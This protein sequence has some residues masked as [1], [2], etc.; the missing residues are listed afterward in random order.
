[1]RGNAVAGQ[2]WHRISGVNGKSV[3]TLF[4]TTYVYAASGLFKAIAHDPRPRPTPTPTPKPTPTPAATPK[5]TPAPTTP[6]LNRTEGIDISHW[7]STIDWTCRRGGRQEV[8]VHQGVRVDRLRRPAVHDEPDPRQGRRPAGRRVPLRPA[9]HGRPGDAVA[10]A[11]HFVDTATP[12]SGDL[13]PVL[14]LERSGGLDA[15]GADRLGPAYLQRIY[16]RTGVRAVIYCS[17][18][19]WKN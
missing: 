11:D 3:Q 14:D 10:E 6:G 9:Q 12:A 15:D 13:L 5:P 4:G 19:F 18:S 7:Q 8:R 2:T 16:E 1:M 17:P